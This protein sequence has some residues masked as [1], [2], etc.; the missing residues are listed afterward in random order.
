MFDEIWWIWTSKKHHCSSLRNV[1]G[2]IS[3]AKSLNAQKAFM[4]SIHNVRGNS[5]VTLQTVHP[6]DH[7][8]VLTSQIVLIGL[9]FAGCSG[10]YVYNDHTKHQPPQPPENRQSFIRILLPF[11]T[12]QFKC[13][14]E[15]IR[16]LLMCSAEL[17]SQV[18]A[19]GR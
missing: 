17:R 3:A 14:A 13:N 18:R 7:N 5:L 12:Q 19:F 16:P 9:A 8:Q 1:Y 15:H 6:A 10:T 2:D 4:R 11:C